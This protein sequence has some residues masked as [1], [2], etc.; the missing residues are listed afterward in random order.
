M[1]F[2]ISHNNTITVT[3]FLIFKESAFFY[4]VISSIKINENKHFSRFIS[5]SYGSDE[6]VKKF[7]E[8]QNL[9]DS[10]KDGEI[11]CEK[12]FYRSY[13]RKN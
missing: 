7:W 4:I 11:Q 5:H 1:S 9:D 6:H 8:S 2:S 12:H 10:L 3:D 13:K